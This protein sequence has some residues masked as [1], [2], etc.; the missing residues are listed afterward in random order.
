MAEIYRRKVKQVIGNGTA[1]HKIAFTPNA[2]VFGVQLELVFPS[3]T[4]YDTMAECMTNI[5]AIRPMVGSKNVWGD[6]VTG[7]RLRDFMLLHGT[8][9]DFNINTGTNTVQLTI[10]FAPEWFIETVQDLLAWN[11]KFLGAP[12]SLEIDF[13]AGIAVTTTAWEYISFNLDTASVGILALEV[14]G[15]KASGTEFVVGQPELKAEGGLLSISIY[16]DSGGSNE[17]TP[18]SFQ[19]G[20]DKAYAHQEVSSV[21]ND[22][23]LERKGL[24]PAASG[25]SAN[26]YDFV[27]VKGDS[28]THAIDLGGWGE[29]WLTIGAAS[30][31]SGTCNLVIARLLPNRAS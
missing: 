31:M 28:L 20:K 14:V 25:R 9:Y 23:E 17:I 13:T 11:P 22:E 29:S 27:P 5:T 10:P 30:A 18:V 24:T 6:K 7:T 3:G 15:T 26:V 4:S 21:Q 19:I 16:P 1:S 2:R 12:I 8:A